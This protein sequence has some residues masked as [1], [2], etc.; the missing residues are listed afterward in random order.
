MNLDKAA[1]KRKPEPN[2]GGCTTNTTITS[3]GHEESTVTPNQP[4]SATE[5][6]PNHLLYKKV[7]FV[8]KNHVTTHMKNWQSIKLN[9]ST[10]LDSITAF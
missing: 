5:E 2:N 9:I 6:S 10:L 1:A 7:N 4:L 8:K 3:G